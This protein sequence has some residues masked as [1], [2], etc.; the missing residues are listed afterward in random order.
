M[1]ELIKILHATERMRNAQKRYFKTR[2]D[3]DLQEAKTS[4]R[5]VDRLIKDYYNEE[6]EPE[7]SLFDCFDTTDGKDH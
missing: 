3:I 1:N 5:E 2:N 6:P 4:E 7:P